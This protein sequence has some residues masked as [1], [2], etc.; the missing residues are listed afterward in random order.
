MK[1]SDK[2][3]T[4]VTP[5]GETG[6]DGGDLRET[7]VRHRDWS[8]AIELIREASEA[9]RFSEERVVDL[10]SQLQDLT[11]QATDEIQRLE[12]RL[13]AGEE[14]LAKAEERVRAAEQR[15]SVAESWLTRLHDAVFEAFPRSNPPAEQRE[16]SSEPQAA[17]S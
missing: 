1:P 7:P 4:L 13:A 15:A 12:A 14:R 8:S 5:P 2:I 6:R 3:I 11:R 10:E 9:I 17:R 16:D